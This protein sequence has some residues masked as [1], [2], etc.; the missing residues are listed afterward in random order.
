MII[1][2]RRGHSICRKEL[3]FVKQRIRCNLFDQPSVK[4]LSN[5]KGARPSDYVEYKKACKTE[6]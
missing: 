5:I 1:P 3:P 4:T 6:I 2:S